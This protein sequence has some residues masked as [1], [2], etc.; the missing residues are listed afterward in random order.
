MLKQDFDKFVYMADIDAPEHL[1]G[2]EKIGFSHNHVAAV[3][4]D[5]HFFHLS[6]E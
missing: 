6:T 2:D 1:I 4:C 3:G 5:F